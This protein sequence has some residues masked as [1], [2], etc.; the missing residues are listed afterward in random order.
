MANLADEISYN[1]HDTDDGLYSGLLKWTGA[2]E[3]ELFA[4]AEE[5]ARAPGVLVP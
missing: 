4:E 3:S 5:F 1:A 2:R